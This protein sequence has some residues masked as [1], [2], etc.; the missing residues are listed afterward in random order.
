MKNIE[1]LGI[2]NINLSLYKTRLSPKFINRKPYK[3]SN[4]KILISY[5]P[6]TILDI[7]VKEGQYVKK[8][9]D[10]VILDAMKMQNIMKCNIDGT[11]WKIYVNMGDKVSKGTI[12]LDLK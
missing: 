11:I 4:P 12:L 2:L 5:I 7:L 1:N 10:L 3:P 9:E 8:G 6:G